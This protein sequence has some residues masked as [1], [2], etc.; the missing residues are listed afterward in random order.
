[1][2]VKA[3]EEA[4]PNKE[5]GR[6]P[7]KFAQP[8]HRA[9][10]APVL[11]TRQGTAIL[12]PLEKASVNVTVG[13][14]FEFKSWKTNE[15]GRAREMLVARKT[16]KAAFFFPAPTGDANVPNKWYVNLPQKDDAN[17]GSRV[18][19]V[20]GAEGDQGKSKD[21]CLGQKDDEIFVQV[22]FDAGNSKRNDPKPRLIVGGA[23][24][25]AEPDNL[26]YKSKVKLGDDRK[27]YFEIELGMAGGDTCE[28]SIGVTDAKDDVTPPL[29]IQNWRKLGYEMVQPKPDTVSSYTVMRPDKS[30]GL[31]D[32]QLTAMKNELDKCFIEFACKKKVFY[33]DAD[34]PSNGAYTIWDADHF[35]LDAGKKIVGLTPTTYDALQRGK[36]T[37]PQQARDMVIVWADHYVN[38]ASFPIGVAVEG[39][40]LEVD[41]GW[42][43][44]A[45]KFCPD[46]ADGT[47]GVKRAYWWA[48]E[49]KDGGVWKKIT[50]NNH[51]GGNK[52]GQQ[53]INF[54]DW[55]DLDPFIEIVHWRKVKLKLPAR[56]TH[57]NDPGH[58]RTIAG[59]QIKI[60]FYVEFEG[61]AFTTNAA[62]W[63]G[64]IWMGTGGGVYKTGGLVSTLLHELGHNLGQGY[65]DLTVAP[66]YGRS[67]A[68][69]IPGIPFATGVDAGGDKY[70][71]HGHTGAHCAFGV[72]APK[73]AEPTY[74][75]AGFETA[76]CIMYG[77]GDMNDADMKT[78]CP[79]CT[80]FVKGTDCL[81]ITQ[82]WS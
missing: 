54:A 31:A 6:V 25:A 55:N 9:N 63:H 73:K 7:I 22:K 80:T 51:P 37:T 75:G 3:F 42:P 72:S 32:D 33:E 4:N 12:R 47:L 53:V 19:C 38:A 28:V 46:R 20:V 67:N 30:A 81:S 15:N 57:P 64:F 50:A 35:E 43:N 49:W 60:G 16:Y 44:A 66:L 79:E 68:H 48:Y 45:F 10:G 61:A 8:G 65:T 59:K 2:T 5:V 29:K 82:H 36:G 18:K 71:D 77:A 23:D 17:E 58:F 56:P 34:L 26:T 62:G 69:A 70:G 24:V 74:G 11:T 52:R 27:A 1:M 21:A 40:E 39:T 41:I 76:S 14:P 78:F 13:S